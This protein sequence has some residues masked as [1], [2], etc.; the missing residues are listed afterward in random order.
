MSIQ[1]FW[2]ENLKERDNSEDPGVDG[3]TILIWISRKWDGGMDCI[4]LAKEV[5]YPRKRCNKLLGTIKW[6][7]FLD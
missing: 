1:G 4:D 2:W 5:V 7:K 3:M 6:E